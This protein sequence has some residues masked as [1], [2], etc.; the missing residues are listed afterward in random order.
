[1]DGF[2]WPASNH[3]PHTPETDI[4]GVAQAWWPQLVLR[5][6][7]WSPRSRSYSVATSPFWTFPSGG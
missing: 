4:D 2:Y 3:R 7:V 6:L 5:P 1:M